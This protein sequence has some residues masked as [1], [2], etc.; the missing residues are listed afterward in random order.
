MLTGQKPTKNITSKSITTE[1]SNAPKI[2]KIGLRSSEKM[3]IIIN[4]VF[5]LKKTSQRVQEMSSIFK[6]NN[7]KSKIDFYSNG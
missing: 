7:F 6:E 5:I 1:L 3:K 4:E 2:I